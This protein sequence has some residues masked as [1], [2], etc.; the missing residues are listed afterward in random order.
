MAACWIP[1]TFVA[2]VRLTTPK[3]TL[4]PLVIG[5]V[6][7]DYDA[8][9]TS[10]QQLYGVFGPGTDWPAETLTLEQ[11][12]IDLGWHQKE[13]QRRTSFAYTVVNSNETT[14]LGCVYIYPGSKPGVDAEVYYWVRA[15][16][17]AQDMEELLGA[18]VRRWVA[19]QWPFEQVAYPGRD[20]SWFEWSK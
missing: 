1:D 14:V 9:M 3:F 6:I 8:V 12:L 16:Q 2:P 11:D 20:I 13:F 4:R 18:T 19:E 17:T 10:R 15:S 5:D 7:K